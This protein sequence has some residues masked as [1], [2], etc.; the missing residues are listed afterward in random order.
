MDC[1]CGVSCPGIDENIQTPKDGIWNVC[2][3]NGAFINPSLSVRCA[4]VRGSEVVRRRLVIA[5][6][7]KLM[8][9]PFAGE[10]VMEH[11]GLGKFSVQFTKAGGEDG[12]HE[13]VSFMNLL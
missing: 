3:L 13:D 1:F 12:N 6:R 8:N 2:Y 7:L 10:Q 11:P 9:H 5:R 4:Q